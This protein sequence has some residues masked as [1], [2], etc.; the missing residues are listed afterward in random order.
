LVKS[1]RYTAE[2]IAERIV[3]HAARGDFYIITHPEGH[4][5]WMVKRYA[6]SRLYLATLGAITRLM[7]REA[8]SHNETAPAKAVMHDH[9]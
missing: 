4:L 5:A 2:E 1:A 8:D 6:P 7:Q 9:P 3:R